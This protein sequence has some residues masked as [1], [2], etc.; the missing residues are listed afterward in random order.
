MA[1]AK[2]TDSPIV[3]SLRTFVM[4]LPDVEEDIACAG[5]AVECAKFQ[6]R[7]KSFLFV[8]HDHVRLKLN[9]SLTEAV[10][11]AKKEPARYSAKPTNYWVKV[12]FTPDN[13]PPIALVERWIEE[14]YH[15]NA[16]KPKAS[17]PAA[18]SKKRRAK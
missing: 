10:R 11:L 1:R 15:L 6:V 13:P 3:Q 17:I 2:N 8:G 7:K 12:S 16:P 9:D 18:S 5:T 14:S 4:R